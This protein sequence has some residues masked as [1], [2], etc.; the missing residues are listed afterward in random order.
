MPG[1][2][3]VY[4]YLSSRQWLDHSPQGDRVFYVGWWPQ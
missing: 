2:I 4:E 3:G 1:G